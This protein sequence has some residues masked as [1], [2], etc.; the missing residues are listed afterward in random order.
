MRRAQGADLHHVCIYFEQKYRVATRGYGYVACS[1]FKSREG[2]H[3]FGKLLRSDFLP[4]GPE[5]AGEVL[6][7][8]YDSLSSSD[9]EGKGLE[10]AFADVTKMVAKQ[11]RSGKR[12]KMEW[13]TG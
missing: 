2:C 1:R 13:Q 3:V 5:K 7:R 11:K 10:Y 6:E 12:M 4:A 8:G 9:D